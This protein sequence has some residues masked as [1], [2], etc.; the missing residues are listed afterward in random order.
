MLVTVLTLGLLGGCGLSF[1]ASAYIKAL[2]DN[3]YKNDSAEFVSQKIGSKEQAAEL[4]DEGI[5]T[6]LDA[7]LSGVTVSDELQEEYRQV[8][9]DMFAAVKYTVG[10]AE[11]Q[12]DGTYVVTVNYQKMNVFG[13]AMDTYLNTLTELSESIDEDIEEE[14][15]AELIYGV[16]KDAIKDA[17]S[18]VTYEEEASTTIRVEL[19]DNVYS[20][21]ETDIYNLETLFFDLDALNS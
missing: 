2:L 13:P 10:D 4:Y 6:E 17:L 15:L 21:N 1:D 18:D 16:L 14:E 11:K 8:L 19:N 12:D 5:Q 7:L 9:K 3:S 20:P